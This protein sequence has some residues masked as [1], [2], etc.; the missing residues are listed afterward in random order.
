V[1]PKPCFSPARRILAIQAALRN[2]FILEKYPVLLQAFL[3]PQITKENKMKRLILAVAFVC[4]LSVTAIA[5]EIPTT[6]APVPGE[7]PTTGASIAGEIPTTGARVAQ[8]SGTNSVVTAI[9]TLL[10]LVV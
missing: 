1:S 8:S 7:I 9:L 5:G 2:N 10:G 4:V 3:H 6:G